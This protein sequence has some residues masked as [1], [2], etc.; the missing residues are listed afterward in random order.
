MAHYGIGP[1]TDDFRNHLREE[2]VK[3]RITILQML[4]KLETYLVQELAQFIW[5]KSNYK[6]ICL[7]NLGDKRRQFD[8][9]ILNQ[10]NEIDALIE[11]KYFQNTN[12][13]NLTDNKRDE[14]K[15]TLEKLKQQCLSVDD[16]S[17]DK[18]PLKLKTKNE[19]PVYGLVF[20]SHVCC[21]EGNHNRKNYLERI[22]EAASEL[23]FKYHDHQESYLGKPIYKDIQLPG[24]FDGREWRVTL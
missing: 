17:Y 10:N 2:C 18:Y 11:A 5:Y 9:A 23:G 8:M 1:L 21:D 16:Y 6:R 24:L 3:S 13:F 15:G 19:K 14:I 4:G 20:V 7:L 12:R 22:R